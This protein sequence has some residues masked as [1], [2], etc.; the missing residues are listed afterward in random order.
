MGEFNHPQA[1][2][3]GP[4]QPPKLKDI[5]ASTMQYIIPDS[6]VSKSDVNSMSSM[7]LKSKPNKDE[8]IFIS[9][10]LESPLVLILDLI[11]CLSFSKFTPILVEMK[12]L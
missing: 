10:Y 11:I 12:K 1:Q 3:D 2:W 5:S 8:I 6:V 7:L 9:A 4:N